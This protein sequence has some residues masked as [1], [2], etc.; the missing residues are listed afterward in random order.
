MGA[1]RMRL[2][3]WTPLRKGARIRHRQAADRLAGH[4]LPGPDQPRQDLGDAPRKP[5]V[6]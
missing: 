4:R 3:R 2:V 1:E 5:Q 6:D